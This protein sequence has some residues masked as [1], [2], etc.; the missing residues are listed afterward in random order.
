MTML[1]NLMGMVRRESSK[2][3]GMCDRSVSDSNTLSAFRR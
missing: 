3:L 1:M 2:V